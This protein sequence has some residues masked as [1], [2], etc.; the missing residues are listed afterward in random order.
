MP[1]FCCLIAHVYIIF[2]FF[3]DLEEVLDKGS[4]MS[5]T[6]SQELLLFIITN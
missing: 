1:F 4:I 3:I 5:K 2:A 6:E